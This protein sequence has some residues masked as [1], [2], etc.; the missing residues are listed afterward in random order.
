VPRRKN[1]QRRIVVW[2]QSDIDKKNC[3][4]AIVAKFSVY[5]QTRFVFLLKFWFRFKICAS[6]THS[7][8]LDYEFVELKIKICCF[9]A[10][11]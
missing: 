6:F 2:R 1:K 11:S 4:I 10:F 9:A 7:C 8:Y 3:Y 5:F